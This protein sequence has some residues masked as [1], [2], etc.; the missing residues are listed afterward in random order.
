MVAEDSA[1][2]PAVVAALAVVS[3][4]EPVIAAA[5]RS[6][7]WA[8]L[9]AAAGVDDVPL[10][11]VH[12]LG[13]VL[14]RGTAVR[15]CGARERRVFE[16][17]F[18][19]DVRA[20]IRA[21]RLR[22]EDRVL[23]TLLRDPSIQAA[24][25]VIA[26]T[27]VARQDDVIAHAMTILAPLLLAGHVW[28]PQPIARWRTVLEALEAVRE[29]GN[30]N[31][32]DGD[33]DLE[34]DFIVAA[35]A[36][37]DAIAPALAAPV[38]ADDAL[39]ELSRLE[40]LPS[41]AARLALRTM[42][43]QAASLPSPS[44]S[45]LTRLKDRRQEVV[46]D[47]AVADEFPAG[48]FD[49]MSTRGVLENLVRSE[50]AWVGVG[51]D[52]APGA[53]GRGLDLFDVRFVEGELLYYTRDESPL[54][55]RRRHLVVVIEDV[56][57]LR[58]KPIELPT[59]TLVLCEACV[60]R[61]YTDLQQGLGAHVVTLAVHLSGDDDVVVD[62]EAALLRTSLASEIAHRRAAIT[63]SA[64]IKASSA[65][66]TASSA[67]LPIANRVTFSPRPAPGIDSVKTG[68]SRG[69]LW[70][71]VGGPI[72]MVTTSGGATHELDPRTEL[73]ALVDLLMLQA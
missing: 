7:R 12:D 47:E 73:R 6:L 11:V 72:W 29:D 61:A 63:T 66:A 48:G 27:S 65:T 43:K 3:V 30:G 56:A 42:H 2:D 71:R 15:L 25:V 19:D 20:A 59:Q 21:S 5:K 46:I 34:A 33:T 38:L 55:E 22:F 13:F 16:T 62:E 36:V 14:L 50:V 24:H 41:A 70:V 9:A 69:G 58:H 32:D 60:L 37:I 49:A 68:T 35:V 23:T 52:D 31:N 4:D 28:P 54:L 45:L 18:D 40:V 57:R 51:A 17:V 10:V 53:K 64:A 39:W 8:V 44:S 67:P 26:G 1:V